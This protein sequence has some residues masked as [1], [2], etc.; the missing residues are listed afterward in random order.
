MIRKRKDATKHEIGSAAKVS[1]E[2]K[3]F[4]R[5]LKPDAGADFKLGQSITLD[6]F[7][8]VK[9]VDVIGMTK[10]KDLQV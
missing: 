2:P 8:N 10:G 6:I 7:T 3:R 5:E 1:Q 4:I 9:Q